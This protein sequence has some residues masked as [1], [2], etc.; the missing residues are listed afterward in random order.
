MYPQHNATF[1]GSTLSLM[2]ALVLTGGLLTACSP[3]ASAESVSSV[4]HSLTHSHAHSEQ[5]MKSKPKPTSAETQLHAAMRTLW[6]QHMAWTWAAVVAFAE[7]SP[8]LDA[9]IARLLNNQV[10]IG[11]SIAPFYGDDAAAQ[12]TELLQT[13]IAQAVPVLTAAKAGDTVALQAALDDWYANAQDIADF[14]AAAN[15]NWSQDEMRDMMATHITQTTA[16]AADVIGGDYAAA[17]SKFDEA[18][19]HMSHMADELSAGLIAQFPK[20]F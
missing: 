6:D 5:A 14:L 9:T 10:D 19:A 16:Y 20:Q 7:E 13:H 15:P 11:D 2:A 18:Q 1:R 12:L 4:T 8:G 17:I 3:S